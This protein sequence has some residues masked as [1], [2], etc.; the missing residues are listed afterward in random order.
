MSDFNWGIKDTVDAANAGQ[1]L[2]M[3]NT[4]YYGENLLQA[5]KSGKV[6]EK[7]ID[8]ASLRIVRTLLAHKSIMEKQ[9]TDAKKLEEH[10]R[11]A[12]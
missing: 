3:P 2:E 7:V 4:H 11:L 12:L 6:T 1:D 8:E 5:V 9:E 10:R